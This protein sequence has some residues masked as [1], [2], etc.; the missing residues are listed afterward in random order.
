MAAIASVSCALQPNFALPTAGRGR[1]PEQFYEIVTIVAMEC[2][3]PSK[4]EAF[5]LGKARIVLPIH[6]EI[7]AISL[8]RDHAYDLRDVIG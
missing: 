1:S 8:W 3:Q 4:I 6:V 2:P 7:P 5:F